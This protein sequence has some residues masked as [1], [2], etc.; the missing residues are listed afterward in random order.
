MQQVSIGDG[1]SF[2]PF[3]FDEDGSATSEVDDV[4]RRQVAD[5]LVVAPVI[6]VG[7]EGAD[8]GFKVAR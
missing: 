3:P 2:D 6:I 4:G 5:A 8:A 1:L 7:D